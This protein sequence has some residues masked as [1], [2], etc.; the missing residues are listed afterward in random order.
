M[1]GLGAIKNRLDMV[2]LVCARYGRTGFVP[3]KKKPRPRIGG[4][5]SEGGFFQ[6]AVVLPHA[7]WH[8][9]V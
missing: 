1:F 4:A 8:L 9:E 2:R 3:V 6:P 5:F 7:I